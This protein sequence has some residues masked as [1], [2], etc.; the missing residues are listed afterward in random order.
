MISLVGCITGI[1]L[2]FVFCILQQHY[3]FIKVNES[4]SVTNNAYP[5]DMRLGD[6][7][8]VFLT[9]TV[10]SVIASAISATLSVKGLDDI[11]QDL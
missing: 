5:I 6:F 9:V 3:S 8:L 4:L 11:K 1:V 7:G 10:I 2:G